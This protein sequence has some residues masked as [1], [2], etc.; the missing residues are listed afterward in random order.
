MAVRSVAGVLVGLVLVVLDMIARL[1]AE[2][3]CLVVVDNDRPGTVGR[4]PGTG[5]VVVRIGVVAG[6]ERRREELE[7]REEVS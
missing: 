4:R 3:S 7:R 1:L 6:L 2:R 5:L